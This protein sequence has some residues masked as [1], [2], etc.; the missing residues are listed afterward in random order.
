MI[1]KLYIWWRNITKDKYG[2][3]LCYCGHTDR[4]TCG[5]PDKELFEYNLKRGVIFPFVSI[6]NDKKK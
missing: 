3:K 1:Y 6:F 4:C 5:N 2:E